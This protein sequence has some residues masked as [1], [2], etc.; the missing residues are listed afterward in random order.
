MKRFPSYSVKHYKSKSEKKLILFQET[1][2]KT[3]R[4]SPQSK[5]HKGLISILPTPNTTTGF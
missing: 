4:A 2:N 1:L 3:S 5:A